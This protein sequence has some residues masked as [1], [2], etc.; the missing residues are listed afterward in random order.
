M[1]VQSSLAAS[2]EPPLQ[3]I[4]TPLPRHVPRTRVAVFGS[5]MGGYHVLKELLFGP[6]ASRV[7][8]VGVATDDPTQVFA[9]ASVRLWHYRF[10]RASTRSGCTGS[11]GR[12]WEPSSGGRWER[13]LQPLKR[14][15]PT[16]RSRCRM[17]LYRTA[18]P[19]TG[20]VRNG[21][22]LDSRNTVGVEW[23]GGASACPATGFQAHAPGRDRGR[24]ASALRGATPCRGPRQ[25]A[26]LGLRVVCA[27]QLE[28]CGS[29]LWIGRQGQ[30]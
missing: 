28:L 2:G 13:C 17:R 4:R 3:I 22:R 8:V 30:Y 18:L 7:T 21:W 15:R 26:R 12:R 9:H 10:P 19:A 25:P 27:E 6:L 16:H 29:T 11:P 14:Y 20:N 5:F 1:N 24:C 23:P